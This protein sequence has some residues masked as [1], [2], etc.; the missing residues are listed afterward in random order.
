M[1]QQTGE[2]TDDDSQKE[3]HVIQQEATNHETSLRHYFY[4]EY[5]QKFADGG[6]NPVVYS[7]FG[8]KF[9]DSQEK[10]DTQNFNQLVRTCN[11]K[12]LLK[13]A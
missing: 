4:L 2:K 12:K 5:K 6:S 11:L 1:R 13:S 10:F 9:Y 8:K 3:V 7:R